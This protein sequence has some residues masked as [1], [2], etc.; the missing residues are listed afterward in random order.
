MEEGGGCEGS[1]VSGSGEGLS[2][3]RGL[4]EFLLEA[5]GGSIEREMMRIVDRATGETLIEAKEAKG[6]IA[7]MRG[8]IGEKDLAPGRGMLLGG[9]QVHTFGM[10]FPI[11]VVYLSA[12]G[13]VLKVASLNPGRFGPPVRRA[14]W[15]LEL[16]AGDA[17]RLGISPGTA[18]GFERE[19]T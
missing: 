13:Q 2:S 12:A 15:V 10:R 16:P 5:A 3:E 11:D 18:L 19:K 6:P 8:L 7:R 14:R 1:A 9:G 4:I 17:E